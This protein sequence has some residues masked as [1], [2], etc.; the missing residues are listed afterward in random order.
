MKI[1][2]VAVAGMISLL[3]A[4][5]GSSTVD[6][7]ILPLAEVPVPVV[8]SSDAPSFA[9]LD[10]ATDQASAALNRAEG[11]DLTPLSEIPSAGS[12]SYSGVLILNDA[13]GSATADATVVGGVALEVTFDGAGSVDATAS[14]FRDLADTEVGGSLVLSDG[15]LSIGSESGSLAGTFTG[16]LTDVGQPGTDA[17]YDYSLSTVGIYSGEDIAVV[18]L[19]TNGE[20]LK[21]GGSS[22]LTIEGAAT[23]EAD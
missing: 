13:A 3:G 17:D 8:K 18:Q 11:L 20:A 12:A 6:H 15:A 1:Q 10:A 16:R 9:T 14:N 7:D 2:C 4:C 22:L 21:V 23:L 19:L 5:G